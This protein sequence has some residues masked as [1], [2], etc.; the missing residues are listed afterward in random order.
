MNAKVP[1]NNAYTVMAYIVMALSMLRFRST[2]LLYFL[3]RNTSCG[4]S[5]GIQSFSSEPRCVDVL[6]N[7]TQNVAMLCANGAHTVVSKSCEAC[8]PLHRQSD[9]RE[10]GIEV[11]HALCIIEL[12]LSSMAAPTGTH[13]RQQLA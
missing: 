5:H 4:Y 6:L 8:C 7:I 11:R 3:L 10:T 12:V 13:T 9:D 2:M 1:L